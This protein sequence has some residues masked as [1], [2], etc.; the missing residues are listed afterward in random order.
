M[1]FKIFPDLR[2]KSPLVSFKT[3]SGITKY[4]DLGVWIFLVLFLFTVGSGLLFYY[5]NDLWEIRQ[6]QTWPF[7]DGLIEESKA[8]RKSYYDGEGNRRTTI[9]ADI[10]YSY[11][12]EG[13]EYW[14]NRVKIVG[15][16]PVDYV[17]KY[18]VGSEVEVYV[19][20]SNPNKSTL[21][22]GASWFEIA[23]VCSI[24]LFGL[25]L[26]LLSIFWVWDGFFSGNHQK[27]INEKKSLLQKEKKIQNRTLVLMKE[28]A[29][30][31]A[32]SNMGKLCWDDHG[33][34]K[35]V[36]NY[37]EDDLKVLRDSKDPESIDGILY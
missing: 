37:S 33:L 9:I 35:P 4:F 14:G 29:A 16:P 1:A 5:G 26:T 11:T 22:L 20:P 31:R 17:Q 7:V 15:D 23:A 19:N 6:S 3:E 30:M 28:V 10:R 36:Q 2:L 18:W 12:Y 21:E 34:L 13:K 32:R 25:V 27:Q 24:N 8:A